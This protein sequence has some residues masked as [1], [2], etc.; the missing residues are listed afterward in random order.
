MSTDVRAGLQI[1]LNDST[2]NVSEATKRHV[3]MMKIY[4]LDSY[5]DL[6]TYIDARKKRTKDFKLAFQS[7][8]KDISNDFNDV[9]QS[10]GKDCSKDHIEA[11]QS[12]SKEI[13]TDL[14]D[15]V[16]SQSKSSKKCN[17][18]LKSHTQ[19]NFTLE[20]KRYCG[21]ERATL[22]KRRTRLRITHFQVIKQIGQGG[23]GQVF[24]ARKKDTHE[25]CAVKKMNKF[26]LY[27]LGETRHILT[28][29][30]VLAGANSPWLVNLL[31]AFQ[32]VDH[33]YLAMVY[34]LLIL[35][36]RPRR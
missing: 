19:D 2:I 3:Q 23:Y 6:L 17:D 7:Q 8:A 12:R 31:Y 21:R 13:S 20:W 33:V 29:R 28:E 25:V 36:I 4:F 10:R 26:A 11:L 27:Q 34:P 18:N 15:A 30:D 22:R 14:K 32:D 35:G 24:L 5:M 1:M 16:Q 9:L